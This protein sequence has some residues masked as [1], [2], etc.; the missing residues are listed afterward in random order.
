MAHGAWRMTHDAPSTATAT[1]V[2]GILPEVGGM[3]VKG[4]TQESKAIAQLLFALATLGLGTVL[5]GLGVA[6]IRR[7]TSHTDDSNL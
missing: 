7:V 5:F 2:V 4:N 3:P 1:H 6:A